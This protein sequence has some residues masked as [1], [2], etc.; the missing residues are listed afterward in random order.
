MLFGLSGDIGRSLADYMVDHGAR[1]IILTSRRPPSVEAWVERLKGRG[2]TVKLLP[3]DITKKEQVKALISQVKTTMPPI[4]GVVNGAMVLQDKLFSSMDIED[5]NAAV[6]PKI[7]GSRHLDE[8]FSTDQPLEFFIMLSSLASVIGNSGQ[9]NY[10]AGNMYCCSLA[11]NRRKRGLAASVIDIG[12]IVGIGYVARNRKAVISLRSHKFQPISEPLFQHMFA[13]AVISGRPGS[14][15]QPVLTSG[16]QKR[17]GLAEEDSAPPLW[18]SNP[19]FSHM[20]WDDKKVLAGEANTASSARIPVMDQLKAATEVTQ[21]ESILCTSFATRLAAILQ[22]S[23]D[24]IAQDTPLVDVGTF[25]SCIL[26]LARE[27]ILT[28]LVNLGIDSLIAVEVRSWFLKELNVDVPVLK[29]I[30][31]ASIRDICRDVLGK[32]S[33]TLDTPESPTEIANDKPVSVTMV[34]QGK[35]PV[36]GV[37]EI[38]DSEGETISQGED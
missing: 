6:K 36:V 27:A 25:F 35:S 13:E 18:L 5:W 15:R 30:G 34:E 26:V 29:V 32:L 4:G 3:N 31:G 17:V 16:M 21:A 10:N 11:A 37:A 23:V 19:R 12:K 9:S 20:K 8:C 38:I 1:H 28:N 2:V 7:D 33:L 14:G 24:S 22:M